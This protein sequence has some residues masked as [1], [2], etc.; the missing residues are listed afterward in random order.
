MELIWNNS[1][2]YHVLIHLMNFSFL[3]QII[4]LFL[5]KKVKKV[6]IITLENKVIF[7]CLIYF[8]CLTS[9][10]DLYNIL[11]CIYFLCSSMKTTISGDLNATMWIWCSCKIKELTYQGY[12][13]RDT[14]VNLNEKILKKFIWK[15][16]LVN[17]RNILQKCNV[18]IY[19]WCKRYKVF[20]DFFAY[21]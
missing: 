15:K 11:F 16:I 20:C 3:W 19:L 1:I 10:L 17:V 6:T 9:V 2:I 7:S 21:H 18:H 14:C 4:L 8:I 12:Y 5:T 13:S